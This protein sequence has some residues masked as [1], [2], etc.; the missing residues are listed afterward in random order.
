[1]PGH[2][3]Q[4]LLSALNA[5]FGMSLAIPGGPNEQKFN[6]KFPRTGTPRPRFLGRSKSADDF[7]DMTEDFPEPEDV[8]DVD[9][10]SAEDRDK[11]M[12]MI[13]SIFRSEKN[14]KKAE[15]SRIKRIKLHI[16]W[17]RSMKRTQRYLGLREREGQEV[18]TALDL[19]KPTTLAPE[20]HVLFI[21]IDLEAYEFNQDLITEIGLAMLDTDKLAGVAP[22]EGGKNW[23]SLIEA[24]HIRVK[25]NTW[26]QNYK[27]V[28]GWPDRFNFG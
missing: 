13:N 20:G 9:K 28:Q 7:L 10:M 15:K 8:D 21:A 12:Q 3:F 24:R 2:Q 18:Q 14:A 22:G 27:H 1:M 5:K 16:A 25:E 4:H 19:S 26:A 17:G 6:M 11:F 23:F